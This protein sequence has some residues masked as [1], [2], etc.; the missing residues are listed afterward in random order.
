MRG[1]LA[2]SVPINTLGLASLASLAKGHVRGLTVGFREPAIVNL[3]RG[4]GGVTT[5]LFLGPRWIAS[6]SGDKRRARWWAMQTV[7]AFLADFVFV[8]CR[9]IWHGIDRCF[10]S[11]SM[12]TLAWR[13][14]SGSHHRV[15]KPSR[16]RATVLLAG[17]P[18][19]LCKAR[20]YG[21][22]SRG[23]EMAYDTYHALW[24]VLGAPA[25][26]LVEAIC[27]GPRATAE[28]AAASRPA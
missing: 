11:Y 28:V 15:A 21:A 8:G 2:Q 24:H 22:I 20:A 23:D 7:A 26:M 4:A 10:A 1:Q 5:L 17:V 13:G 12:V 14:A 18:A 3:R 19:V 16:P 6:R 25:A 27:V 9:S